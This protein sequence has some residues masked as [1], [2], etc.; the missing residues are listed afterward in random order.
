MDKMR[1]DRM[2]DKAQMYVFIP[3]VAA[4]INILVAMYEHDLGNTKLTLLTA[5]IAVLLCSASLSRYRRYK[6]GAWK[7][8]S[9][10]R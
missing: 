9:D 5:A 4:A 2:S 10:D 7:E 6:S 3:C 8:S 1:N